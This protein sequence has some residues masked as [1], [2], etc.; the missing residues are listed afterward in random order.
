MSR[1]Q[2][3]WKLART[4]LLPLT[5]LFI[6]SESSLAEE[7]RINPRTDLKTLI[8]NISAGDCIILENG[9]WKDIDLKLA[10]LPGT[11]QSPISIRAETPGEVV[12]SGKS[13]FRLSGQ[14]AVVSGIS[15]RDCIGDHDIFETRTNKDELGIHFRITQCAFEQTRDFKTNKSP[16]WLSLHGSN[17]RV[18]HCYFAGKRSLGTTLVVWI[19]QSPGKHRIDHNFFGPRAELGQNGGETIR[20]GTS[21][22]SE[23]VCKCVVEDNYFL[24]CNGE[25]EVI[26][27][28]SCENIFRHNLFDQCVGTLTL[29][30]GHRCLV[31]GNVFLGRQKPRTGGVRIIG[32]GHRVTNNYFEGLRGDKIRAAVCLMNGIPNGPL[33]GYAPVEDAIVAHN[34]IIDS[35]SP[36][37]I[38]AG[39]GSRNRTVVPKNCLIA[40]NLFAE[41]KRFIVTAN[42]TPNHFVWAGN[43][44][45]FSDEFNDPLPGFEQVD[46]R[47]QRI[48]DGMLRPV[49]TRQLKTKAVKKTKIKTDV[50]GQPR[51]R[52]VVAGCDDPKTTVRTFPTPAN[53]GPNWWRRKNQ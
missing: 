38:G 16:K 39:V 34:T 21:T 42:V 45:Q 11:N 10:D 52:T 14:H 33:N 5:L 3:D 35:E 36:L 7:H 51:K 27:N 6:F 49:S 13:R 20:I 29:R 25:A 17:H 26:S 23:S 47:L 9:N 1:H 43:K 22:R 2:V 18:D 53:T 12:F 41:V 32:S 37:N 48:V 19:H 4:L 30:H 50:D 8:K 15:F 31:D 24:A 46:L 40:N 44:Q 28:K